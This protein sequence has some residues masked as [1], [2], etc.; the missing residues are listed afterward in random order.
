MKVIGKLIGWIVKAA[1]LAAGFIVAI[2]AV[3]FFQGRERCHY[4][5]DE[6]FED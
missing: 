2:E 4:L 6:D 5:V 3:D 1:V